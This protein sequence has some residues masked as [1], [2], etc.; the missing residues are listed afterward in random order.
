MN[1]TMLNC[2]IIIGRICNE[3]ELCKTP[4][5]ISVTRFTV[6]VIAYK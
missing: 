1:L 2:A 5:G 3:L 6:A 4:A